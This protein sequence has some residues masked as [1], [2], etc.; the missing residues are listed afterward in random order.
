MSWQ[1]DQPSGAIR[2]GNSH[3]GVAE[4]PIQAEVV[5]AKR[6]PRRGRLRVPILLF[7]ATCFTTLFTGGPAYAGP[8]MFILL[9]HEFGHYLQ[10][11]RYHVSASLPYFIPMPIG[12]LGT[13]GAVIAMRSNMGDRKALFD[14]G[15]SGPLAGMVPTLICC[16]VGLQWSTVVEL[17]RGGGHMLGEP[18]LFQFLASLL[19]GPLPAGKEI[20]LHPLAYAGWVGVLITALNLFPIGQLDGGHVLYALLR[21]KA[22]LV[23]SVLLAV[24]VGAVLLTQSYQWGLMLVLLLVIGPNHPPTA[25][26]EVPLGAG[27]IALGWLTL[28]FVIVGFTPTPFS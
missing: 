27:R 9:C 19:F 16:F 1:S 12:D 14:I 18:L 24:A 8:L 25:N 3:A 22:R 10:A 20:F 2:P 26:D 21:K 28:M 17:P 4:T 23:A 13:M 6:A 7:V 15:I 11:R 5:P